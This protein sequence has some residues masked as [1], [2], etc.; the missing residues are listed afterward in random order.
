MENII[1][2]L[3]KQLIVM[4]EYEISQIEIYKN[5]EFNDLILIS[6]GKIIE[7][8]NVIQKLIDLLNYHTLSKLK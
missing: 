7:L 3:I 1:R 4:K 2:S 8:D 6:S 5:G